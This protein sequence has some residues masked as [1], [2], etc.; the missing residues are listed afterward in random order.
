INDTTSS[1][2]LARPPSAVAGDRYAGA[3]STMTSMEIG[4][5]QFYVCREVTARNFIVY[6]QGIQLDREQLERMRKSANENRSEVGG[7]PGVNMIRNEDGTLSQAPPFPDWFNEQCRRE[8][9][10]A[11]DPEDG[12]GDET[13][14]SF[15]SSE[16][17][18][19]EYATG[20]GHVTCHND[21]A[22]RHENM[23]LLLKAQLEYYFSRENLAQDRYL[24]CQMDADGFVA[25]STIAGF[26]KVV[27]LTDNYDL[28]VQTLR[29][30]RK[31]E[32]D[33]AGE[34]VRPISQRCTIILREMGEKT[35]EE[36]K[37][38]LAGGPAYKSLRTYGNNDEW[39]VVYC[40]EET[41]KTAYLHIQ[42]LKPSICAR[43]KSGPPPDQQLFVQPPQDDVVSSIGDDPYPVFDLGKLLASMGYVP[44]ATYRPG[45]T[46]VQVVESGPTPSPAPSPVPLAMQQMQLQPSLMVGGPGEY[47]ALLNGAGPMMH[48]GNGGGGGYRRGSISHSRN[49]GTGGGG[50]GGQSGRLPHH[51]PRGGGGASGVPAPR[52]SNGSRGASNGGSLTVVTGKP[53][54]G[55]DKRWGTRNGHTPTAHLSSSMTSLGGGETTSFNHSWGSSGGSREGGT[56]GAHSTSTLNDSATTAHSPLSS[57]DPLFNYE[58]LAFPSLVEPKPAPEPVKPKLSFSSVAAGRKEERK[59]PPKKSFAACLKP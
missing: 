48:P 46:V 3:S 33:D 22:Q 17:A 2:D 14:K 38:M 23:K 39:Y 57:S 16:M 10:L 41:T 49:G 30:S 29:E 58:D 50:A 44:R 27:A 31:V 9:M 13:P 4:N 47:P 36:V 51:H 53:I 1:I 21:A 26:R 5:D 8:L 56:G 19:R 6:R 43:I 40:N 32:V 52:A 45:T 15:M 54:R 18:L 37:E 35:E 7:L 42:Q 59:E 34:R 55:G 24:K 11:G 12:T 20:V 28:I 25:I